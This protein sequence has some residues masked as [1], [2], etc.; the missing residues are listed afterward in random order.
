MSTPA[1]GLNISQP[2]I[3][4]FDGN[5]TFTGNAVNQY[6][7]I[8]GGPSNT[9]NN[10]TPGALGYVLTSNGPFT[11]PSYQLLPGGGLLFTSGTLTSAQI[12]ALHGTP[13]QAIAAPGNGKF[14]LVFLQTMQLNYGG[15]NAFVAAAGQTVGMTY[16]T[17]SGAPASGA[18]G[19]SNASITATSNQLYAFGGSNVATASSSYVNAA[20][21]FNNPV[22]TEIT[23]N[24]AN[25]NTI[26]YNI[27][28]TIVTL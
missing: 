13:V 9:L 2:G 8:T 16:G 15:N 7:T 17:A 10:V 22:A 11:Q 21:N 18:Q 14:I 27:Y 25:N 5:F 26:T 20:V 28:Y 24:A 19:M 1:N 6:N 3:V 12:K 4:G 23:G